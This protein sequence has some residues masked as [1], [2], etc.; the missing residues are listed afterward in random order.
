MSQWNA[1]NYRKSE[2]IV[3]FSYQNIIAEGANM[4]PVKACA[5]RWTFS[6]ISVNWWALPWAQVKYAYKG[7]L[8]AEI[9]THK[10]CWCLDLLIS[11]QS[12]SHGGFGEHIPPNKASGSLNWNVKHYKSVE[13]LSIFRMSSHPAEP[14][15]PLLKTFWRRFCL[16][17]HGTCLD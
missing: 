4:R 9:P 15:S 5:P 14:Q 2:S 12:R 1:K 3:S 16:L 7:F 17:V 6:F 10:P 8:L 11:W 13:F